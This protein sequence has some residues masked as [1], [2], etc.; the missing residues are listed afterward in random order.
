MTHPKDSYGMI[1]EM[2]PHDMANDPRLEPG[3]TPAPWREHP[4]GIDGLDCIGVAA[5]D[6]QG[7]VEFLVTLVGAEQVYEVDRPAIKARATGLRVADH[8]IEIVGATDPDSPVGA[9]AAAPGPAL[10]S[11]RF[12][13]RD[14]ASV[15]R[16]LASKGLR[17]SPGDFDG[18]LALEPADN[19]GVLW[20]FAE[21]A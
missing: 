18:S 19:Y 14:L 16:H 15:D 11:I 9:Y 12:K 7:A 1:L 4:M 8:I 5:A 2:C 3:W 13:V 6:P 20:Q 21:P 17:T 10:R